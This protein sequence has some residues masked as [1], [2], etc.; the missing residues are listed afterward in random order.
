PVLDRAFL[1]EGTRQAVDEGAGNLALDLCRIDDVARIGGGHDAMH[2]DAVAALDGDL[3]GGG[4]VA[5]KR[6]HLRQTTMDARGRR[7]TPANARG[8]RIE[9]PEVARM[10]GQEL[11]PELER[12]LPGRVCQ[13][14]HE[15]LEEYAVLVDVHAPPKAR[16]NVRVAHRMV[17]QQV[18]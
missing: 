17:D 5:A 1:Q 16:Q 7:F 2:L 15:T 3:G 18:R 14:V 6:P 8:D 12:V 9:D 10:A 11:A 13:L 4:N